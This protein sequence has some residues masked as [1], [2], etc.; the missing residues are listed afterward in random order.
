[1]KVWPGR[2]PQPCRS[3][4]RKHHP[5]RAGRFRITGVLRVWVFSGTACVDAP[6]IAVSF[7]RL[8]FFKY[9]LLG[10]PS[11]LVLLLGN[12][13]VKVFKSLS[14]QLSKPNRRHPKPSH[15]PGTQPTLNLQHINLKPRFGQMLNPNIANRSRKHKRET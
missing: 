1:M 9:G 4:A 11:Y 2:M 13:I 8:A 14:P 7:F 12:T 5:E 15:S 6:A 3:S 10:C